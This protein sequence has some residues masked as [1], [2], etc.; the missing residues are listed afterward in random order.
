MVL[1]FEQHLGKKIDLIE[2]EKVLPPSKACR[3]QCSTVTVQTGTISQWVLSSS[4]T[5]S[6]ILHYWR[7]LKIQQVQ[8][9][10]ISGTCA[11]KHVRNGHKNSW[12]ALNKYKHLNG[13]ELASDHNWYVFKHIRVLS[14]WRSLWNFSCHSQF[15]SSLRQALSAAI[16]NSLWQVWSFWIKLFLEGKT[17]NPNNKGPRR[18][19]QLPSNACCSDACEFSHL[20]SSV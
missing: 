10:W 8:S 3:W 15:T 7:A 11:H 2:Y 14:E 17:Q 12:H 19:P 13:P 1:I 5:E 4:T 16:C 6:I 18:I 9:F 20:H